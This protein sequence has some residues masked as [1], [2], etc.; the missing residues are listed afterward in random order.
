M[1]APSGMPPAQTGLAGAHRLR[2]VAS[3]DAMAQTGTAPTLSKPASLNNIMKHAASRMLFAYWDGARGERAAPERGEIEPGAI[4]HILA[5]TFILEIGAHGAAEF[6][7]AGTRLCA[8]FGR[9]LRGQPFERLW[10]GHATAEA[11]RCVDI[12]MDE[13][14][15][16]VTGHVGATLEG[17]TIIL[18]TL[19]LPLRHGGKTH[20]LALGALSPATI[21]AWFG[22]HPIAALKTV[23][24]RVIRTSRIPS[25]LN[26][27]PEE[28]QRR[29]VVHRGGRA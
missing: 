18:E 15:G 1:R 22:L 11:R 4:R 19:L 14:S 8:L 20:A 24:Q 9:E 3:C 21:P 5:D 13:M 29:F 23:S 10:P 7:L 2:R 25:G 12:V 26:A 27:A 6:R 16:L 17:S 28:R